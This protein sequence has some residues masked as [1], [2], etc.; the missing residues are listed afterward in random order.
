MIADANQ[1]V[2]F[3]MKVIPDVYIKSDD[4]YE[5]LLEDVTVLPAIDWIKGSKSAH[6]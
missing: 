2:N 5:N 3:D 6:F 4:N 1:S